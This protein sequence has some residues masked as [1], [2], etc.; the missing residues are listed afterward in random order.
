[1]SD[2]RTTPELIEHLEPSQLLVVW[3]DGH[4]SLFTPRQLRVAC[5]CAKCV[6]EWSREPLLD[7]ATVSDELRIVKFEPTGNYGLNVTFSDRHSTGIYTYRR[8]RA[9]DEPSA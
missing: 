1:M 7:P 8:L 2:P 5:E 9:L 4:E 6:D 3:R